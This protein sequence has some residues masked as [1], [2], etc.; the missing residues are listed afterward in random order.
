MILVR[1]E[2]DDAIYMAD[3]VLVLAKETAR[4]ARLVDVGLPRLRDRNDAGFGAMRRRMMA[5]FA[6]HQAKAR[7]P[8]TSAR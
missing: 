5:E 8:Q 2:R 6:L 1:H 7:V 4:P 3:R